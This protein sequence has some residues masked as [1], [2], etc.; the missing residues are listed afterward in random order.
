MEN[1]RFN[2]LT[3]EFNQ[4][5]ADT[6]SDK[7]YSRLCKILVTLSDAEGT[8]EQEN[9]VDELFKRSQEIFKALIQKQTVFNCC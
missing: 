1:T 9:E 6:I 2:N 5:A 3:A 4:I 7:N 8:L